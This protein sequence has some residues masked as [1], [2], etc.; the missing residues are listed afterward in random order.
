MRTR[1]AAAFLLAFAAGCTTEPVKETAITRE[2]GRPAAAG[3]RR[4]LTPWVVDFAPPRAT[5]QELH[6]AVSPY[7]SWIEVPIY[8]EV[9]KPDPGLVGLDWTPYTRG[10]WVYTRCGWCWIS[11]FKKWGWAPFHFG[12][13]AST[14][15]AGWVWIP[16]TVW[17]PAHVAWREGQGLLGWSPVPPG[18]SVREVIMRG[19]SARVPRE[20]WVFVEKE[21]FTS[22][23]LARRLLADDPNRLLLRYTRRITSWVQMAGSQECFFVGPHREA[24]AED[25]RQDIPVWTFAAIAETF[26]HRALADGAQF[27]EDAVVAGREL[28]E[29]KPDTDWSV[30]VAGPGSPRKLPPR[31]LSA[32]NSSGTGPQPQMIPMPPQPGPQQP[33]ALPPPP[34]PAPARG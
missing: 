23:D 18:Y 28:S 34:P 6:D 2:G 15:L 5:L 11:D 16:G 22:P 31:R 12:R 14:A 32:Y 1:T 3:G 30:T 4:A 17:A 20:G 7:G 33:P 29:V 9:W 21:D 10:R 27:A 19:S 25:I 26:T 13:W 8:G 24:L